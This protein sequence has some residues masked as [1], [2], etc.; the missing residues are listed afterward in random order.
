M[1]ITK[2]QMLKRFFA[3]IPA[4]LIFRMI[5]EAEKGTQ[6]VRSDS[7]MGSLFALGAILFFL[8]HSKGFG[9]HPESDFAKP[10]MAFTISRIAS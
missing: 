8:F 2:Y 5:A 9:C 7:P 6:L 10:C 4:R 1:A 3:G